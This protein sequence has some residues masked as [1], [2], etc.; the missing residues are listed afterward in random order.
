MT[1]LPDTF[2][3]QIAEDALAL[4]NP[5]EFGE[6]ITYYPGGVLTDPRTV[7][8]VVFRGEI[9]PRVEDELIQS[10]TLRLYVPNH[11]QHGITAHTGADL[12]DVAVRIG[13]APQ[14][15][16]VVRV[17][18]ADEGMWHLEAVR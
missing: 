6:D 18:A 1:G 8:A 12:A 14:T 5:D 17:I 13:D 11:P 2:K 7:R 4:A 15:V 16:R 10:A 3:A 9:A